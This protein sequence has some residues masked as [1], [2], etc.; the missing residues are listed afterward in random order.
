MQTYTGTPLSPTVTTVPSGLAYTVTGAPDTNA[1]S[2]T[3]TATIADPN[4]LGS[5]TGTFV[6]S[7]A[8]A[9]ATLGNLT[10]TYT[11]GALSPTVTTVPSGLTFTLTGAPDTAAG[12]YP[13]TVTITDPNYT[14]SASGTFLIS[15]PAATVSPSSINFGTLRSGT[16]ASQ[17]V[18]LKNSGTAF[19]TIT[20]IK[21]AVAPDSDEFSATN[22]CGAILGA[23]ASCTITV[24]Y[25]AD[26]D[27]T[28]GTSGKLVITDNAPGSPQSVPLKGQS[29]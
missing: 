2:Y 28:S 15:R 22:N 7:K 23:G 17:I 24:T 9:T 25:H 12:S 29:K 27:D 3:V 16:I 14:G 8:P 21:I 11:G 26:R 19:M 1:G 5:N 6:I 20:S 10:Q 18:T 4:Y 13:V